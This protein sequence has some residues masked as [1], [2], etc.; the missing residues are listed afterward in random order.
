MKL[1]YQKRIDLILAFIYLLCFAIIACDIIALTLVSSILFTIT[2]FLILLLWKFS[3]SHNIDKIDKLVFFVI[4][5]SLLNVLVNGIINYAPFSFNYAKN[6]ILFWCTLIYFSILYKTYHKLWLVKFIFIISI[7]LSIYLILQFYLNPVGMFMTEDG[8]ITE[9]LLMKMDNPNKIGLV[10][11]SIFMIDI[12]YMLSTDSKILKVSVFFVS[13]HLFVFIYLTMCRN[14]LMVSCLF[15]FIVIFIHKIHLVPKFV[16]FI[17]SILPLLFAIFYMLSIE[18]LSKDE[19]LSFLVSE[20][21]GLDSRLIIWREGFNGL[22]NS[23]ILG[24]YYEILNVYSHP[25][26]HNTHLHVLC[27]FGLLPFMCFCLF[28]YYTLL[29]MRNLNGGLFKIA[30]FAAICGIF[31]LGN[32]EASLVL[33]TGG[34]YIIEGV[35]LLLYNVDT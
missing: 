4:I 25:H 9:Y 12:I 2:F 26:L 29:K 21:K 8:L 6:L 1:F 30:S 5:F 19:S 7:L 28:I 14:A 34:L 11:T 22:F 23:P 35:F 3:L 27:A 33:G 31:V 16:I 10:L 32:G 17:I 20:G 18:V 13:L 24:S 15:L